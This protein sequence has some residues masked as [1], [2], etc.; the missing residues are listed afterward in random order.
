MRACAT[1]PDGVTVASSPTHVGDDHQVRL[2]SS[3]GALLE[4]RPTGYEFPTLDTPGDWDANWLVIHGRVR[5]AA[6]GSWTFHHPSLT[7]WE[8]HDLRHWL[9]RAAD[10][11]VEPTDDPGRD[12]ADVLDF[13]E[14]NLAFS[15]AATTGEETELRVHLSLE[16]VS[17]KPGWTKDSGPGLHECSVSLRLSRAQLLTSAAQWSHDIAPFPP[18]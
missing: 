6:G 15:V 18:R 12:T 1:T 3:D 10:G 16:A 5:T 9:Q 4:L 17:G 2:T 13:T 11:Q 7:T 8:A 14:P